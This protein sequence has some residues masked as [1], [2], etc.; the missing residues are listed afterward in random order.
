MELKNCLSIQ[1][2]AIYDTFRLATKIVQQKIKRFD[3]VNISTQSVWPNSNRLKG[4]VE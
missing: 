1:T 4:K 2:L 3:V